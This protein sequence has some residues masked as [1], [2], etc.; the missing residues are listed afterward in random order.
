MATLWAWAAWRVHLGFVQTSP[1]AG[2]SAKE[3]MSS[4]TPPVPLQAA[5]APAPAAGENGDRSADEPPTPLAGEGAE[6]GAC[7]PAPG[8][9]AVPRPAAFK[10]GSGLLLKNKA[11]MSLSKSLCTLFEHSRARNKQF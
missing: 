3:M 1:A 8:E 2:E 6:A 5:A 4:T 7:D 10:P 9:G 11:S